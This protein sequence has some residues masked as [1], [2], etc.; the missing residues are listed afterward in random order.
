MIILKILGKFIKV[1]RSAASPRQIAWG[2]ALGAIIGL[3]P[4]RAAHNLLVILL[5]LILNVNISAALLAFILYTLIAWIFDPLFHS[6]GYFVLVKIPALQSLWTSL[7]NAPL[8]PFTRFNNTVVM[9]SLLCS[10][11]LLVP[12]YLLFKWFVRRYRES[13][14]E[15]ITQ[16]KISKAVM[17]S[18]A[19][20]L[21][22]RIRNL[23]E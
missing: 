3:T 22:L 6:L 2:F 12:N 23:G 11:L 20:K 15:K 10:L 1:L 18:K 21:Y 14:N 8:A 13:W 7:Y 9:G 17:G 5:I 19:V 4:L 16:L